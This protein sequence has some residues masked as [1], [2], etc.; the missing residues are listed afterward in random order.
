M[1]DA[2]IVP[3][4]VFLAVRETILPKK[5]DTFV[6]FVYFCSMRVKHRHTLGTSFVVNIVLLIVAAGLLAVC[7]SSVLTAMK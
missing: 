3:D 4:A 1:S 5:R 6:F 2:T 7:V